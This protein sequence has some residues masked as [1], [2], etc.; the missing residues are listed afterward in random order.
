MDIR[1]ARAEDVAPSVNLA[2][3]VVGARRAAPLVQAAMNR[4]QLLVAANDD[5]VVGMLAF[6]TDWFAC[7]F[8]T[9]VSVL[10]DERRKGV[11]RRL[12]EA[13]E[14][15][16]PGP[17]LFSSTEETNVAAIRMHRA[18][19]FTESGYVDNLPQGYR[20]LLFFKRLHAILKP[21]A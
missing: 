9:L 15:L 17:R 21:D 3:A 4:G 6:R 12:F 20:E 19:G 14:A 13:V 5:A 1:P 11:A 7:T 8:V 10:P 16:S 18:L 2:D